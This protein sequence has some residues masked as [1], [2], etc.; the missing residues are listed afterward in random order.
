MILVTGATGMV[1]GEICRRLVARGEHVRALVRPSSDAAKVMALQASGVETVVGDLRDRASL[2]AACDGITTVITTVS[3]MPF[4]YQAGVNDIRTTDLEGTLALLD[5]ARAASVDRFVYL[6]FSANIDTPCPLHDAKRLVESRIRDS[7]LPW[8]I[9]RPSYFMEV[10]LS[11][12]VGFDATNASATIYGEGVAPISWISLVD[13]AELTTRA[14]LAPAA[15]N[16]VLELGGPEPISPIDVVAVFE[17]VSGRPFQVQHVPEPAL[18]AQ[19]DQALDPMQR[20][21]SALMVAYAKGDQIEMG[22]VLAELPVTLTSV[23]AH[24]EHVY[25]RIPAGAK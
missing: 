15:A 9:V 23:E 13:V 11:P 19:M 16:Q 12:A 21:F 18:R 3:S 1:G 25:G 17:R 10:W 24:A 2:A 5:A 22:D 4:S 7:G 20:S 8:T 14:A 6:S